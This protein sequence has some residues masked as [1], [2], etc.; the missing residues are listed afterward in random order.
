MRRTATKAK[1]PKAARPHMPGYGLPRGTKGLLRW[2][3][4][5]QRLRR[6]HN[7]WMMTVRPGAKPHAMPVWGIWVDNRFYFSTG[8]RSRKARNLQRNSAC[9]VCTERTAEAVIV[10][11]RDRLGRRGHAAARAGVLPQVQTVEAR[12]RDGADFR[13]APA[14]CVRDV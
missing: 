11:R 7:Y 8:A 3:W 4:A 6:S 2:T 14:G 9:I 5:E 12:P 13:S 10:E 1:H